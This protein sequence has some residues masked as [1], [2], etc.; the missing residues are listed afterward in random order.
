VLDKTLDSPQQHFH[1]DRG[2]QQSHQT[3][4]RRE[5][6]L[7]DPSADRSAERRVAREATIATATARAIRAS[8]GALRDTSSTTVAIAA[9][10]PIE[11]IASRPR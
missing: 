9:G 4:E 2:Q 10:R 1:G 3:L 8:S 11:G 7:A 5:R 6:P